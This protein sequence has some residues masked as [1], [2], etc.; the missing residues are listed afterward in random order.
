MDQGIDYLKTKYDYII[1][2]T[3]PV[4]LVSDTYELSRLVDVTFFVVRNEV[5]T[6]A[7]VDLIN[8]TV[9]EEKLPKV[10][11]V[12]NGLNL[13][14]RKY[15]F[16]YGYGKYSSYHKY[17]TYYGRYGHYGTYGNYGEAGKHKTHLEK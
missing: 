17:G 9:K 11:I 7:E 14:K 5:T 8:R 1:L 13:K 15:G 4:G 16:Y 10:N 6:K 2:D 3:P 12:F